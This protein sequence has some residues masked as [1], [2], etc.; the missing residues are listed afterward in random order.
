M[1]VFF[2]KHNKKRHDKNNNIQTNG[3]TT[4]RSSLGG[5][6]QADDEEAL[7]N[8]NN[9]NI[10]KEIPYVIKHSDIMGRYLVAADDLK[11]GTKIIEEEAIVIGPCADSIPVCLGCYIELT[12][13]VTKFKCRGCGWPLC[14]PNC[15]GIKTNLGHSP[16]ECSLLREKRVADLLDKNDKQLIRQMYEVL[17]PLKCLLLKQNDK[18]KWE[19]IQSMESH[20]DL[21]KKIPK[22]W[23]RNQNVIVNMIRNIWKI[24]DFTEEEIHTVCGVLEVNSFEIGQNGA[25]ARALYPSAF[26][27]AH[28]CTPNTTHSD[29]PI[30]HNLTVRVTKSMKKDEM[31]TLSY[32]YTL[33]GTLKRREHLKDCKFFWCSCTRCADPTELNTYTSAMHCPK[34]R[35]GL[36][37]STDPLDQ[38]APWL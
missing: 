20:N 26:L 16:W 28:A 14:G 12:Q 5:E 29:H 37:L 22:I 30:T 33:Q 35:G 25:R 4:D 31:F 36:I 6:S 23:E 8:N 13:T 9:N 27:L 7:N 11:P 18:V 1:F 2:Q 38:D 21:R 32:A 34:C 10:L 15:K 24:K 3:N 17:L 19:K